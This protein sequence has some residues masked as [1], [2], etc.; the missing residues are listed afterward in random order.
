MPPVRMCVACR[1]AGDPEDLVRLVAAP[2]GTVV[3]D[4][5]GRLPGRGA[6]IHA[7]AACVAVIEQRRDALSKALRGPVDAREIRDRLR[8][9]AWRGVAD[10]L[11]LAAASGSVVG[12]HDVLLR[13][14]AAGRIVAIL[15]A[16]DAAERTADDVRGAAGTVPVVSVPM[17]REE[18]GHRTGRGLR[19]ALGVVSTAGSSH[20]LR[21]LRRWSGLG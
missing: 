1:E 15:L 2:D 8:D 18:L 20:L 13:E 3:V 10:G 21:Q 16:S 5:R 14:L 19:A 12:G 9:A 7:T 17:T 6:W 4:V 11:S